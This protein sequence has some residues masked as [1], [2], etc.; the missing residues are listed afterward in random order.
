M[1]IILICVLIFHFICCKQYSLVSFLIQCNVCFYFASLATLIHF[2]LWSWLIHLEL[3]LPS[4]LVIATH[5]SFCVFLYF[6]LNWVFWFA[7][8][9]L[10]F[11]IPFFLHSL[12]V[13]VYVSTSHST[14]CERR[15]S[16]I[17]TLLCLACVSW[18][19]GAWELA[20][21]VTSIGLN[22]KRKKKQ[23]WEK[24]IHIS[25]LGHKKAQAYPRP[26]MVQAGGCWQGAIYKFCPGF[27]RQMVPIQAELIKE[28]LAT[29]WRRRL[30]LWTEGQIGP[31]RVLLRNAWKL[32]SGKW[33]LWTSAKPSEW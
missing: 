29:R 25:T 14:P 28:I 8:L 11:L 10:F 15:G 30:V 21:H 27:H 18:V 19:W 33:S 22:Q 4:Y 24:I 32:F 2:Y 23:H 20:W 12:E 9:C 17:P 1:S 3:V 16:K 13:Y 5:H 6:K 26:D 31:I 7:F